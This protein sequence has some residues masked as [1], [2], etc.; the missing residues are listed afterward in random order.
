MS[1]YRLAAAAVVLAV[2]PLMAAPITLTG[3]FVRVTITDRGVFSNLFYDPTGTRTFGVN[4]YV[5]PGTP[6]E[7]FGVRTDTTGLSANTNSG[8]FNIAQVGSLSSTGGGAGGSVTW[9]GAN[10]FF[11][12]SHLYSFGNT[13]QRI[14]I[15]TTFTALVDLTNVLISRAVDPDPDNFLHG[16]FDTVNRRGN[17]TLGLSATDFVG[18]AGAV[19]GLPLGLLYQGAIPHN[20]G[21]STDCCSTIDPAFYL[22][23]GNAGDASTADHGIGLAFNL[24]NFSSGQSTSWSYSY[25]MGTSFDRIDTGTPVIPEPSSVSLSALGLVALFYARR[26]RRRESQP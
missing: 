20:T 10:S 12:I 16:T 18:S 19:S 21:I 25:V 8:P 26:R 9:T 5:A 13:D 3:D 17:A 6:F 14:G 15:Q 23:G 1:F 24:G 7:G 11:E 22:A 4:D 2:S